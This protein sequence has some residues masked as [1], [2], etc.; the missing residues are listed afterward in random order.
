[1][2]EPAIFIGSNR[3]MLEN[4]RADKKKRN[5]GF[6]AI[7]PVKSG[8]LIIWPIFAGT[9]KQKMCDK[10]F[11][12]NKMDLRIVYFFAFLSWFK[13]IIQSRKQI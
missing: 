1:M 11:L 10:I 4:V 7:F 3:V 12:W 5:P 6:M 9:R 2:N 13:I 8:E